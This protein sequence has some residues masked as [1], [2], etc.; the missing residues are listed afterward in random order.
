MKILHIHLNGPFTENWSYQENHL[1]DE[2]QR[3]GNQ[4][5]IIAN[6]DTYNDKGVIVETNQVDKILDSGVRLIRIIKHKSIF[7]KLNKLLKPYKIYRLID[8]IKPD[9]IV[10]HGLIGS[11]AAFDVLKYIKKNSHKAKLVADI[12]EDHFVGLKATTLKLR[13]IRMI[14]RK[15]NAKFLK[16]VDSVF[17]INYGCKQY[18]IDYYKV[19]DRK[20][21][22]LPLGSDYHLISNLEYSNA[23][24]TLKNELCFNN[25][26][27]ICHG[28]KLDIKKRTLE[29]IEATILLHKE[30]NNIRL[31]IF[32]PLLDDIRTRFFDYKGSHSFISY[33]GTLDTPNFYKLFL[34]ADIS[35]FPGTDSAL[36]QQAISCGNA[37]VLTKEYYS[38]FLDFG[39]NIEI[40]DSFS[41]NDIYLGLKSIISNKKYII[42]KSIAKSNAKQVF[43]YE[44]LAKRMLI[45]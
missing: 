45:A 35:V 15:L 44:E 24:E 28:G 34:A 12:H 30:F 2:H 36:W 38:D 3:M 13:F 27:I 11:I 29:L 5:T 37:L 14:R 17:F 41:P 32:G 19:P 26:I 43:S 21:K 18:A 20:L 10:H 7:K 8:S 1:S 9:F 39:G 16:F 6:C 40:I 22:L 31:V 33:L 25:E 42:M 23:G 4:V